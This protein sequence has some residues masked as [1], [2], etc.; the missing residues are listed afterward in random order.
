MTSLRRSSTLSAVTKP[1]A[2]IFSIV[3][4]V[5]VSAIC[6]VGIWS[7]W[8][9]ARADYLFNQRTEDSIRAAIQLEPDAWRYYMVLSQIDS[10]H[11][12]QLLMRSLQLNSYNAAAN[13]ELGLYAESGGDY[14]RAEKLLVEA[15]AI[16][17]TFVTRWALANF[18]LRRGNEPAFW[19]WA[20]SAASMPSDRMGALFELCWRESPDPDKISAAILSDN[21]GLIHQYIDFLLTKN[22]LTAAASAAH[23]LIPLGNPVIDTP[24]LLTTVNRLVAAKEGPAAAGLWRELISARWVQGDLAVV[25]NPRFDR[26]PLPV[27]FD[28][29]LPANDGVNS[30]TG[31]AGLVADFNGSEPESWVIASQS[32]VLSPGP[33]TLQYSYRTSQIAPGTGLRWQIVA[34]GTD[35]SLANSAD[36]AS[37]TLRNDS[38]TFTVPQDAPLL[39]LLLT[40]QR[41][42]G[43]TRISGR[44]VVQ[45]VQVQ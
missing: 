20:R 45:S 39:R 21:P 12:E 32:I 9:L 42:L 13:I 6:C 23:R 31:S 26:D 35:S 3:S 15:F 43:T 4:R 27:D 2:R 22:Q 29:F 16:D 44:L 1:Q 11:E 5:L 24:V 40:Y 36:L 17:R 38:M 18:Y 33:H 30:E 7:S 34:A 10:A 25:N 41:T 28:W 14:V 37:D 8:K 19:Q